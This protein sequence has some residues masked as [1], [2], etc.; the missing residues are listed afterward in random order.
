MHGPVYLT[1]N[2]STSTLLS[3]AFCFCG[4]LFSLLMDFHAQFSGKAGLLAS[5]P[6]HLSH[7]SAQS[8]GQ[9]WAP[10]LL[11]RAEDF[12]ALPTGGRSHGQG[13]LF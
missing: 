3:S 10:R 7:P 12:M 2:P 5:F 9:P 4:L 13:D 8:A 6:I 1:E 11:S